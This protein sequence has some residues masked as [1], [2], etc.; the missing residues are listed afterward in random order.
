MRQRTLIGCTFLLATLISATTLAED[1]HDPDLM[2]LVSAIDI[3]PEKNQLIEAGAQEDGAALVAIAQDVDQPQYTRI[4]AISLLGYFTSRGNYLIVADIARQEAELE[5]VRIA[6]LFMA[7]EL[8][9]HGETTELNELVIA[10]FAQ[11]SLELQRAA[12]RA[13]E[14][15]DSP[16]RL[17]ILDSIALEQF[18]LEASVQQQVER[19]ARDTA[20][21]P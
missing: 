8:V 12:L 14:R 6:A 10:F 17:T 11:E 2:L 13:G 16:Q 18:S 7:T 4:R 9:P 20:T 1:D 21:T 19:L 3:I 5:E 15:F